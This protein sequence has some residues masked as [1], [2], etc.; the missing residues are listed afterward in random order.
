MLTVEHLAA[1]ALRYERLKAY[2]MNRARHDGFGWLLGMFWSRTPK[3][4]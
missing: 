3:Q 4:S 1:E 2:A